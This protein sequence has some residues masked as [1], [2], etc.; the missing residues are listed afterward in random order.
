MILHT[1]EPKCHLLVHLCNRHDLTSVA[2]VGVFGGNLTNRV[3]ALCPTVVNYYCVDPWEVYCESYDRPAS[4]R[5]KQQSFWEEMHQKVLDISKKYTPRVNII[6]APSHT[7]ANS[8]K[9]KSL[10]F[11]YIDAIHDRKNML[12][13]IKSWLPKIKRWGF[14]GGHDFIKRY[15]DMAKA[16]VEVFEDDLNLMIYDLNRSIYSYGNCRQG[17]NWWVQITNEFDREKYLH[18]TIQ[19]EK[20][21]S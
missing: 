19:L 16:I 6:R 2:E 13:D 12:L 21:I 9:D 8:I 7:G 14:I 4:A 17:G 10:D 20:E 5:E 1:T 18:K 15:E 3:M 11:V